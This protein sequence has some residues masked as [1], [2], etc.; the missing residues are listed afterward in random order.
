MWKERKKK[1]EVVPKEAKTKE[2]DKTKIRDCLKEEED[3]IGSELKE[4]R[5]QRRKRT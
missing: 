4:G 1:T 2:G 3:I 5:R